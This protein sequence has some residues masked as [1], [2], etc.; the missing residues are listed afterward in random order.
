MLRYC[1]RNIFRRCA[2]I[3]GDT[4]Q[5]LSDC[6][7]W[8]CV[9]ASQPCGKGAA[10]NRQYTVEASPEKRR[11]RPRLQLAVDNVPEPNVHRLKSAAWAAV[12]LF[13]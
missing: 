1:L 9:E 6:A 3:L 10:Y 2:H 13:A 8:R 4:G 7:L 11:F 12:Q 5:L